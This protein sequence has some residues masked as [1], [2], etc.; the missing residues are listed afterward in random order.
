VGGVML[1]SGK[2]SDDAL[3]PKAKKR[4]RFEVRGECSV[5]VSVAVCS[6]TN[7]AARHVDVSLQQRQRY[8]LAATE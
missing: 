6:V 3:A 4:R 1:R 8:Q 2:F 7:G 5:L